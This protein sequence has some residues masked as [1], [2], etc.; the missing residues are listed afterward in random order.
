MLH[1]IG[2]FWRHEDATAST[3]A[4][5]MVA[6]CRSQ[7]R[8]WQTIVDEPG[9]ALLCAGAIP[10]QMPILVNL[11]SASG[12]VLGDLFTRSDEP[13]ADS[14]VRRTRFTAEECVRIIRSGGQD[15][16]S[17]YWGSY[18]ALLRDPSSQTRWVLRGPGTMLPCLRLTS[19][20]VDVYFSRTDACARLSPLTFS[21][22]WR[23]LSR[24]LIG[25]V[26]SPYTGLNE[27]Q[28]ILPGFC[29]ETRDQRVVRH[30]YWSPMDIARSAPASSFT[31]AA[32]ALRR[33][34]RHCVRAWGQGSPK[35][36]HA[37]SGGLD[38]SIVLGCLSSLPRAS[39]DDITC[40][41][42]FADGPDS[43][44]RVFARLA[45]RRARCRHIERRQPA[46][47]DLRTVLHGVRFESSPG[48]R[49][50]AIDRI[51]PDA[52]VEVGAQLISKGHGG[53]ELFCRHHTH[54]YVADFLR[55]RG[56]R[57]Q[58]L[59]LALHSA[60]MEG[61]T[62]WS[63]MMRALRAAFLTREWRLARIFSLDQEGQWLLHPD[64]MASTLED[65]TFDSPFAASPRRCPP[66]KLWQIS[67]VTSRRPYY[68]PSAREGDPQQIFPLL[69]Q[70]IIETCLRI[71][72]YLQMAGRRDRAV[73]RAAFVH[74]VPPEIIDRRWKGGA[75]HL[76][77]NLLRRNLGFIR[78]LLLDGE[79]ARQRIID[80]AR[81][82]AV[83]SSFPSSTSSATVPVFDLVGAEAWLQPW[84]TNGFRRAQ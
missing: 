26:T 41:T 81:V 65:R 45:A 40:I 71:P 35:I 55:E 17:H 1:Y 38:S 76:A 25:P 72:T 47:V 36:L 31:E 62:V 27:V 74:E 53:D 52:A 15:L 57:P 66:G 16:V 34:T 33:T 2:F 6:E 32:R 18:V 84:S 22:N 9:F 14:P 8:A 28:E 75:E 61:V 7:S 44:E 43:D 11:G 70:P 83:L 54:Y 10:P 13:M 12:A 29:E 67:L 60:M 3:A 56:A 42:H 20:G 5:Q 63:V 82:E 48:M 37:L 79:L 80:R 50:P 30:C 49:I 64:V 77:W 59:E 69:S 39:Q 46:D 68:L 78:E 58:L 23:Q 4:A 21:I 24:S 73:A 51:E 19:R